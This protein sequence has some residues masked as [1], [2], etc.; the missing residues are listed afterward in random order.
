MGNF[1]IE[2]I[3]NLAGYRGLVHL[4]DSSPNHERERGQFYTAILTSAKRL[5]RHAGQTCWGKSGGNVKYLAGDKGSGSP[6]SGSP[7]DV[8]GGQAGG[9]GVLLIED[10]PLVRMYIA[11][12]LRE[13]GYRVVEASSAEEARQIMLADEPIAVVVSDITLPGITGLEFAAWLRKE[14]P[15]VKMILISALHEHAPAAEAFGEFLSK[16]FRIERLVALVR[17]LQPA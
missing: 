3:G 12:E 14:F 11:E 7:P 15:D 4:K 5:Q 10:E 13:E 6:I 17:L 2:A 16:P 8:P 1:D 9:L